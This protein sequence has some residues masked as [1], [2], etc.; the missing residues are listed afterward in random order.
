MNTKTSDLFEGCFGDTPSSKMTSG[1]YQ[2]FDQ[3]GFVAS[4]P[5]KGLQDDSFG[6][7]TEWKS[8]RTMEQPEDFQ[9]QRLQSLTTS[10]HVESVHSDVEEEIA[11]ASSVAEGHPGEPSRKEVMA[12]NTRLKAMVEEMNTRLGKAQTKTTHKTPSVKT[13]SNRP[14]TTPHKRRASRVADFNPSPSKRPRSKT[15]TLVNMPQGPI[16]AMWSPGVTPEQRRAMHKQLTSSPAANTNTSIA[17]PTRKLS[18][19]KARTP[20]PKKTGK[21]V[22]AQPQQAQYQHQSTS[23]F[24]SLPTPTATGAPVSSAQQA[25]CSNARPIS[26]L[27]KENFM[28]L[29]MEEKARLLFPLLQG[30]DPETGE[31]WT[32]CGTLALEAQTAAD[33]N[34]SSTNRD[35]QPLMSMH[36]RAMQTAAVG[37]TP[38]ESF[39]SGMQTPPTTSPAKQTASSDIFDCEVFTAMQS[40]LAETPAA[41]TVITD[42]AYFKSFMSSM[43]TSSPANESFED[44]MAS[45]TDPSS[46]PPTEQSSPVYEHNSDFA[47]AA[48]A[49]IP[50]TQASDNQDVPI[51]KTD[52]SALLSYVQGSSVDAE[53]D[54]STFVTQPLDLLNNFNTATSEEVYEFDSNDNTHRS[55][56][57]PTGEFLNLEEFTTPTMTDLGSMVQNAT[58]M[59]ASPGSGATRQREALMQHERRAAEGRRR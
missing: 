6:D 25:S 2:E 57:T 17:A 56:M 5:F 42:D 18:A 58:A 35:D 28:S 24:S 30:I 1:G 41:E 8:P 52:M 14:Q 12:E 22:K 36:T 11:S 10:Q 32:E 19:K 47:P 15:P 53:K 34:G 59:I 40:P 54:A 9:L 29:T 23:P 16:E 4:E 44:F 31:K 51:S 50:A 45:L 27:Y 13:Q 38:F 46:S 20:A 43:Q 37:N 39:V 3:F 26:V 7:S 21:Q 49:A 55:S 48:A 33:Q